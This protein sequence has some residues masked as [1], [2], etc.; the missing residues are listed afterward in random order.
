M[1]IQYMLSTG[2]APCAPPKAE[3]YFA[4][5]AFSSRPLAARPNPA[6]D[7]AS[8]I[9]VAARMNPPHAERASGI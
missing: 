8:A 1:F 6:K 4:N 2:L 5:I 7:P 9:S 3:D